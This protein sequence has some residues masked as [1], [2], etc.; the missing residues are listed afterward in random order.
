MEMQK[1]KLKGEIAIS[2]PAKRIGFT[3]NRSAPDEVAVLGNEVKFEI[4]IVEEG[5]VAKEAIP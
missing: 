4:G 2:K 5:I 3:S 1:K